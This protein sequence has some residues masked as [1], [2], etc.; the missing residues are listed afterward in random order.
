MTDGSNKFYILQIIDMDGRAKS[1]FVFRKWGRVGTPVGSSMRAG[2]C[3]FNTALEQFK[4]VYYDKT[5]F[6][7]EERETNEKKPGRYFP[8][9]VADVDDNEGSTLISEAEVGRLFI[10]FICRLGRYL[11]FL[12][13]PSS[14]RCCRTHLWCRHDEQRTKRTRSRCS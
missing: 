10:L 1:F 8:L 13:G 3:S 6:R 5:G 2:P 9:A 4:E 7:W 11:A 14:Q 12:F